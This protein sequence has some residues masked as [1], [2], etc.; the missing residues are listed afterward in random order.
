MA[1]AEA[2]GSR[3]LFGVLRRWCATGAA[4]FGLATGGVAG[5]PTA[6]SAAGA[7]ITLHVRDVSAEELAGVLSAA[8]RA[9]VRVEGA[10]SR[11]VSLA[12]D[13]VSPSELIEQAAAALGGFWQPVLIVERAAAPE[14]EAPPSTTPEL[15]RQPS[16]SPLRMG[17]TVTL[18]LA[19]VSARTALGMVARA[20]G[21]R[22]QIADD[23]TGSVS[24]EVENLP[25]EEAMDGLIAQ[26]GATW[27]L[28]LVVTAG[29]ELPPAP[30]GA[31]TADRSATKQ[32][33]PVPLVP[34]PG[35]FDDLQPQ[36]RALSAV[37]IP[38][39]RKALTR[40][41]ARLLQ[42]DPADRVHAAQEY[43]ARLEQML[44]D[45]AEGSRIVAQGRL[46]PLRPL[47]KSGLRAFGGLTPDQ[48]AEFRPVIDLL[49]R[50]MP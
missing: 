18:R 36:S 24:A 29:P 42:T 25:V 45:A 31:G 34:P 33:M 13:G 14:G 48:K 43:A 49:R 39:L 35:V 32:L 12:L 17:R 20:A 19:G 2:P 46:A 16:R 21:A 38:A 30:A 28:G 5:A 27:R 44:K 3:G 50:W 4:C 1:K 9:E 40:D 41:L 6:P 15:G 23:F 37:G 11:R 10:G 8:L 26:I 47:F 22:L 7:P